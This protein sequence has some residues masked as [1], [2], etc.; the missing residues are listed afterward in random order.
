MTG[1]FFESFANKNKSKLL[2]E[3]LAFGGLDE[4]YDQ[5]I[6]WIQPYFLECCEIAV[7]ELVKLKYYGIDRDTYFEEVF[8]CAKISDVLDPIE[9]FYE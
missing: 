6:D 7:A 5:C 9:K 8:D 3:Y 1:S 2:A 4:F